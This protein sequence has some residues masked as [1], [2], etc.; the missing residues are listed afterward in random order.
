MQVI[1]SGRDQQGWAKEVNCTG[2][3]NG[4]GGCGATLLVE[5]TDLFYTMSQ[6]QG[7]QDFY[8]TFK[9][10]ACGILTDIEAPSRF[11]E[12][13]LPSERE[14]TRRLPKKSTAASGSFTGVRGGR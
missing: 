8:V 2:K 11:N 6:H 1:K 5:G 3:G 14:W 4:N 9:C 7:E 12:R 13:T 10:C